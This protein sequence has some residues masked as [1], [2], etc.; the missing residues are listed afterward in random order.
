M[1]HATD[2]ATG[3][4]IL[5]NPLLWDFNLNNN[6]LASISL[7]G[8]PA[9]EQLWLSN[10]SL[11][12]IDLT[13]LKGLRV[14]FLDGNRFTFTTL[15]AISPAYTLYN[16]LS[17]QPI[18]VT[19]TEGRV[20]LSSQAMIGETATSYHWFIDSPYL[21]ESGALAGE[22]LVA[23]EEYT[24]ENGVTTFH[25]NFTH[26]MCVMTNDLFPGLYLMTSFINVT[27]SSLDNIGTDD[28]GAPVEYYNLQGIRVTDPAPGI[29]IR[30]QG[31]RVSK[32]YVR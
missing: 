3:E 17:Q 15:P 13:P 2:N 19:V 16:Y 23:G 18:D 7:A 4:V 27:S 31:S 24:L 9:I 20:D 22:E 25:G 14:L 29:Y 30:R 1:A 26:I 21:D 8:A 28:S 11:T 12:G 5:D 10:N 32:V 6:S